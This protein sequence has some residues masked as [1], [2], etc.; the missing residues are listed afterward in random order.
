[1]T[2]TVTQYGNFVRISGTIAET[3]GELSN[4]KIYRTS[5]VVY[6][7]D[8]GTDSVALINRIS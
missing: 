2:V 5:Q 6:Y 4:Q 3:L 1:M 7:T 8:D